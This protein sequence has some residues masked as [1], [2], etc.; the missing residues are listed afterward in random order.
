[1]TYQT[2]NRSLRRARWRARDGQ[3][4]EP[5]TVDGKPIS[6]TYDIPFVGGQRW[7]A[8]GDFSMRPDTIFPW[9]LPLFLR[10][11]LPRLA[12][13]QL[14]D[15]RFVVT[16]IADDRPV[17]WAPLTENT[18]LAAITD[19]ALFVNHEYQI[20]RYDLPP[21]WRLGWLAVWG[22]LPA[23]GLAMLFNRRRTRRT[24]RRSWSRRGDRPELVIR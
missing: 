20:L 23:L 11:I 12:P 9:E 16:E 15:A 8:H 21:G 19:D 17:G 24:S 2:E 10:N 7:T 4:I 14:R 3:E 5:M 18:V 1:M 22:M 6:R 13:N